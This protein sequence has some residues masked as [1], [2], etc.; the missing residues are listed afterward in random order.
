MMFQIDVEHI[1][2]RKHEYDIVEVDFITIKIV[3]EN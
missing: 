2:A 1:S 3:L